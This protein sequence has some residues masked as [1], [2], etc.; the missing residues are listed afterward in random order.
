MKKYFFKI[1][2]LEKIFNKKFKEYCNSLE[3]PA[4]GFMKKTDKSYS[5]Y[6][7][8][9]LDQV[10]ENNIDNRLIGLCG[11]DFITFEIINP[12]YLKDANFDELYPN[13]CELVYNEIL[14]KNKQE[15]I[16]IKNI[17]FSAITENKL[18][19]KIIVQQKKY[20]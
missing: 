19:H 3:E 5:G 13:L 7:N 14:E 8:I 15:L 16:M 17:S 1:L 18:R 12:H 4:M 6:F 9:I 2:K 10:V 11:E 20:E